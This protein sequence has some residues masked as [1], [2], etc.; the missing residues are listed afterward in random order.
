MRSLRQAYELSP[1]SAGVRQFYATVLL[2]LDEDAEAVRHMRAIFNSNSKVTKDKHFLQQ[3]VLAL[4]RNGLREELDAAWP[5]IVRTPGVPWRTPMQCPDQV[6]EALLAGAKP[7]PDPMQH[8]V[9]KIMYDNRETFISEFEKFRQSTDWESEKY[10]RPNQDTDL[11][12]GNE[13]ARWT[14]MLFFEKGLWDPRTC[15]LMPTVCKKFKNLLEIEGIV[16]GRRSGQVSLLKLQPGTTLVPH[17]GT[18]NWRYTSHLGL[19]VPKGVTIYAG[20]EQREFM[21]GEVVLL[22]DSFL[23]SVVHNGTGPRVT[24]FANFLHPNTKPMTYDEWL[25]QKDS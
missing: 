8:K 3:Y 21:L 6:D 14:E 12:K 22:D 16:H 13:G 10:F 23:H 9:T 20:G 11:V 24:L 4:H 2:G 25:L 17:F 19:L 18:A 5:T 1:D 15:G 7:F